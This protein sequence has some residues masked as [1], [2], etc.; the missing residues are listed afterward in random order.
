MP[1]VRR[2][3][4]LQTFYGMHTFAKGFRPSCDYAQGKL[5]NPFNKSA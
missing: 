3:G 4:H 1:A 5:L 2:L